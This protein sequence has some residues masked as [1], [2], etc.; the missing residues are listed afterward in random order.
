M[1]NLGELFCNG[2]VI[3][4]KA[5]VKSSQAM[6]GVLNHLLLDR[7][8]VVSYRYIYRSTVLVKSG[9]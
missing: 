3:V 5:D 8:D 2:K 4:S 7:E 6:D 1:D 9:R